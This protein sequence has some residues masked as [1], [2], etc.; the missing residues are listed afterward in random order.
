MDNIEKKL[1]KLK[2]KN[3]H[4]EFSYIQSPQS[5]R[6][7]IED[8]V[9]MLL[10]SNSYLDLC[11]NKKLKELSKNA[12][13]KYG[14]GAGGSRLTSGTFD[15]N[16][17]LAEAISDLKGTEDTLIYS[18]G[19]MAN[20]GV[21][22]ALCD[23]NWVVF[24]DKLNHAS[25][26]DGCMLSGAKLVR[27]KHCDM[28]DLVKK[29]EQNKG[30]HNIII[31]DG[32]FSMDGDIAPLQDIVDIA[33]KYEMMT[34]VDD[35]HG[36]GV[37]G[38]NGSGTASMLGIADRIDIHVGTLSKAVPSIGGFVSGDRVI[39]DYIRNVSRSFIYTTGLAPVNIATALNSILVI[40]ELDGERQHLM[41][42]SQWVRNELKSLGL[43]VL[44]SET[45]I[46]PVVIGDPMQCMEL[47]KKLLDDGIYVN[48]IRPPTVPKNTSR[49]RI[50]LM[51]SHSYKDM[52]Y[53]ISRIRYHCIS[54]GIIEDRI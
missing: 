50:S 20:I 18:T 54:L 47:K 22:S 31:T 10:G 12:I 29:I 15:I 11:N 28:S 9:Y 7:S 32:V 49:L 1:N 25:I 13:D 8:K 52:E 48:A 16:R 39:I 43:D 33:D 40:K 38:L 27:Y 46:I 53:V 45:P 17:D 2:E 42:L 37:L 36:L 24:G 21:I 5:N 41:E 6:V 26:V 44:N 4:R 30:K 19:Y 14:L 35:A 51:S 34:M 3:L 23:R